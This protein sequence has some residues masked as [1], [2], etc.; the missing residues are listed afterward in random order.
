MEE[1]LN[2]TRNY[3]N[4]GLYRDHGYND[5]DMRINSYGTIAGINPDILFSYSFYQPRWHIIYRIPR[6]W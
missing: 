1:Y 4:Q 5:I 3:R 2:R 6:R